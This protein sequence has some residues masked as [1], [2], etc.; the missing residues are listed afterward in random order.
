MTIK[1]LVGGDFNGHAGSDMCTFGEIHGG[2]GIWQINDGEITLL[3]WA[4]SKMLCLMNTYFPRSKCRLITFRS[5]ETETMINCILNC[6]YIFNTITYSNKSKS[7]VKDV[8]VIPGVQKVS[9]H[10]LLLMDMAF[11]K[12]VRRKVKFRKK[13]N[14]GSLRESEVKKEFTELLKGVTKN[15]MANVMVMATGVI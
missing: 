8:K 15:V 13:L 11:K 14:L 6:I 5:G 4:I 12:R 3:D 1:V 9:Q 7:S 2:L 10:C